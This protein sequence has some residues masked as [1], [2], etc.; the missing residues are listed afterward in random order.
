M[1]LDVS[2]RHLPQGHLVNSDGRVSRRSPAG[3]YFCGTIIRTFVVSKDDFKTYTCYPPMK[4]K[5]SPVGPNSEQCTECRALDGVR[6]D[7]VHSEV[8]HT[9]TSTRKGT[10]TNSEPKRYPV[11]T[12]RLNGVHLHPPFLPA[13]DTQASVQSRLPPLLH[14]KVPLEGA[15]VNDG[16]QEERGRKGAQQSPVRAGP[17]L[18]TQMAPSDRERAPTKGRLLQSRPSRGGAE[19][20]YTSK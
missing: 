18:L 19:G 6:Y 14:S 5:C 16:S 10:D 8:E 15:F 13:T 17:A 3:H 2:F 20:G 7:S 1:Q 12:K 4:L 9:I 11:Q